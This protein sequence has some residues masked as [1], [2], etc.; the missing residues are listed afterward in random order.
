MSFGRP[1]NKSRV[2]LLDAAYC[3]RHVLTSC[4]SRR[5]PARSAAQQAAEEEARLAALSPEDRKKAKNA[6]KKEEDR[7][8]KE[9]EA[10]AKEK[11]EKD[12]KRKGPA[13]KCDARLCLHALRAMCRA[14]CCTV[15]HVRSQGH[16][17]GLR[18]LLA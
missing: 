11:A 3:L 12:A 16:S 8:R 6:K 10:A 15:V 14:M 7:K 18:L 1:A 2:H 17:C 5:R 9:A 13:P 4:V